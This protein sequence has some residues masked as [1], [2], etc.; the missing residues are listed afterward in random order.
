MPPSPPLPHHQPLG[1][2]ECPAALSP[3]SHLPFL[4]SWP[5]HWTQESPGGF[6]SDELARAHPAQREVKAPLGWS[7]AGAGLEPGWSRA[8]HR[9]RAASGFSRPEERR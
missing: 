8:A 7:R 4:Y 9:E 2:R 6:Q 3:H 1:H 5:F